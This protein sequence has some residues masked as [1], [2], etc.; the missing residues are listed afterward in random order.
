MQTV[1]AGNSLSFTATPVTGYLVNIWTLDDATIQTGG[2]TYILS[3]ITTNHNVQVTFTI[4]TFTITPSCN[5][6]GSISPNTSQ[7]VNYG[8]SLTFTA[9]P[10]TGNS[11]ST[12]S[13]DGAVVQTGG[14]TYTLNNIIA[15]HSVTVSF[16][17]LYTVTPSA[18]DNGSISPNIV[19][20]VISGGSLNFT[21]IPNNGYAVNYW[22][23][24]GTNMQ[25]GGTSFILSNIIADHSVQVIF[26]QTFIITPSAESTG[27]I[28]PN[29]IQTVNS[30]SSLTFTVTPNTGY[31][32]NSWTVDG[33]V[34]QTGGTSYTFSNITNNHTVY[35][36]FSIQTFTKPMM[37]YIHRSALLVIKLHYLVLLLWGV[38]SPC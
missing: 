26:I 10:N 24:D 8:S 25:L 7:T 22:L 36:S 12:W 9:S 19:Q 1:A 29:S 11:V 37:D 17:P 31:Q 14:T 3:N 34:A 20:T 23:V 2:T 28:N 21:A 4:Q 35:V 30:G 16:L 32:V 33:A 18:G 6:N 13:L 38:H 15:L 5:G 27:I